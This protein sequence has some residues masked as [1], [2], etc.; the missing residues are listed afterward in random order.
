MRIR[1]I[2]IWVGLAAGLGALPL[3][4]AKAQYHPPCSPFPLERPF[5]VSGAIIGTAAMIVTAPIRVLTGAPPFYYGAYY[6]RP[7]YPPPLYYAPGYYTPPNY[8]G[9]R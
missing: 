3:W 9:P 7:Y 5:C 8:Y 4:T 6:G 1:Q 2:T